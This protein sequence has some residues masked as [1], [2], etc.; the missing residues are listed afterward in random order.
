MRW[1]LKNHFRFILLTLLCACTCVAPG[2]GRADAVSSATP[3]SS[4]TLE[5]LLAGGELQAPG[6]PAIRIGE[7]TYRQIDDGPFAPTPD[8][9]QVTASVPADGNEINLLFDVLG[10]P[11]IL[12]SDVLYEIEVGLAAYADQ[13]NV[14]IEALTLDI[15]GSAL[16]TV[17]SARV[18]LHQLLIQPDATPPLESDVSFGAGSSNLLIAATRFD[19][20]TRRL[21]SQLRVAV[22]GGSQSGS[23]AVLSDWTLRLQTRTI[24]EP[25]TATWAYVAAAVTAA[26][27]RRRHSTRFRGAKNAGSLS[28]SHPSTNCTGLQRG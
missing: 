17:G 19:P 27:A 28:A 5:T 7:F 16:G 12:P 1:A 18:S 13:I 23:A 2:L 22:D 14:V 26:V 20:P 24:P 3:V 4:A 15:G 11:Q 21:A 10:A 25:A 6:A 9:V 8:Q